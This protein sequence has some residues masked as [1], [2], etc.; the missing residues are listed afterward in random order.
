M[1]GKVGVD[2]ESSRKGR[3]SRASGDCRGRG[4]GEIGLR[5]YNHVGDEGEG[6]SEVSLFKIVV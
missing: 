1:I 3:S 4:R 6:S 2:A 5:L